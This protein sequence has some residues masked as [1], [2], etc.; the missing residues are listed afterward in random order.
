MIR[1]VGDEIGFRLAL[2]SSTDEDLEPVYLVFTE[3]SL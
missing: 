3:R 1:V 2:A